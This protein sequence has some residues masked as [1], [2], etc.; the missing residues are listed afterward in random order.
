MGHAVIIN[1]K[2]GRQAGIT[3]Q[4]GTSRDYANTPESRNINFHRREKTYLLKSISVLRQ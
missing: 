3:K 4:R 1:K 2:K